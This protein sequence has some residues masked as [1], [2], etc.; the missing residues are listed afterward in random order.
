MGHKSCARVACTW[1]SHQQFCTAPTS[2]VSMCLPM[3][4]TAPVGRLYL[5]VGV[6]SPPAPVVRAPPARNFPPRAAPSTSSSPRRLGTS[7]L[8]RGS[9]PGSGG[10][11]ARR[12]HSPFS[13]LR[14][15]KLGYMIWPRRATGTGPGDEAPDHS[16]GLQLSG[17]ATNASLEAA[18]AKSVASG[19]GRYRTP[20]A[21]SSKAQAS[22]TLARSTTSRA[23]CSHA[24]RA[25][26]AGSGARAAA[27][28]R[29]RW[30]R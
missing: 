3:Y 15:E 6:F 16:A 1:A 26:P 28:S 25:A 29:D 10:A 30:L 18:A 7:Q 11:R 8:A 5:V 19:L 17:P 22:P 27:I 2:F 13:I 20:S 14:G 4:V 23:C 12:A 24:S 9:R 21:E